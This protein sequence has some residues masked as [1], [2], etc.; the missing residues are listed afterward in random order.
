MADA[1]P[2]DPERLAELSARLDELE[3]HRASDVGDRLATA[4][5]LEADAAE[6]GDTTSL[7]R[8]RL[9]QGDMLHRLGRIPEGMRLAAGVNAWAQA[10]RATTLLSRS[11]LVLSSLMEASGDDS[12]AL[13][14]AVRA[15]DL[16]DDDAP[17]RVRGNCLLRLADALAANQSADE[18]RQ[19]YREAE[20]V[21]TTIGDRE[22]RLNVLNNLT[23]LEYESGEAERA[24]ETAE[25]LLAAS[26][27]EDLNQACADTI[28]RARLGAG[29]LRGAEQAAR[30]GFRLWH[31]HGDAQATTP[32][33][34][35]LTLTEILLAQGRLEDADRRLAW[36]EEIC[37]E[38]DLHGRRLEAMRLRAML[39]ARRG[40]YEDAYRGHVEYHEAWVAM[41]SDQLDAA[42]RTR[43]VLYETAEARRDADRFRQQ[44]RTDALTGLP[45]RR[46]VNEE[47]GPRLRDAPGAHVRLVA[48]LVDVD[49]FKDVNDEYSHQV[50]DEVL[51][52]LGGLLAAVVAERS[53]SWEMAARLGGEE[54]LLLL[55]ADDHDAPAR[56]ERLRA[57]IE[58]HDWSTVAAGLRVTVSAGLVR[59]RQGDDQASLL[60]RADTLLYRAKRL[61]RNRVE[62]EDSTQ[63]GRSGTRG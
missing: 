18:A 56:V 28:A 30:L 47:L 10:H 59:V 58:G 45:N 8:A 62:T 54:F 26:G 3:R 22:R 49:H 19:R 41:R 42:A 11:H 53:H 29:D 61:G 48:A 31:V 51:R 24:L 6:L 13:D 27:A 21:F 60:A 63:V 52:V 2:P 40:R 17:L 15:I 25:E 46:L 39:D 4:R 1:S 12:S 5:A 7:M 34:L 32:A 36:C 20:Q 33:E 14:H 9:V 44:A 35:G 43:Q 55:V 37:V 57:T 50:G 38:R 23:V 16:V